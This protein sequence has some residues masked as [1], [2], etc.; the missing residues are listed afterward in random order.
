MKLYIVVPSAIKTADFTGANSIA[1]SFFKSYGLGFKF[2]WNRVQIIKELGRWSFS[3]Y[4]NE[5]DAL[6][7]AEKRRIT[8]DNVS[9][10]LAEPK[11][12]HETEASVIVSVNCSNVPDK[13]ELCVDAIIDV[14]VI[15]EYPEINTIKAGE[16]IDLPVSLLTKKMQK[17]TVSDFDGDAEDRIKKIIACLK[18]N[19]PDI[20]ESAMQKHFDVYSEEYYKRIAQIEENAEA[21][22]REGVQGC[23]IS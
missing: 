21:A 12:K 19:N 14:R 6:E 4:D 20:D 11:A 18:N 22:F 15:T 5:K 10:S 7:E 8:E 13:F 2:N 17:F 1:A 16:Q 23:R 3:V 9:F